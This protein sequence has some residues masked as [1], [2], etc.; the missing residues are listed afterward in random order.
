MGGTHA[1]FDQTAIN[2]DTKWLLVFGEP[3]TQLGQPH[4]TG[5]GYQ[6]YSLTGEP[7]VLPRKTELQGF[8]NNCLDSA[9]A[10]WACGS[11]TVITLDKSFPANAKV[12][13]VFEVGESLAGTEVEFSLGKSAGVVTV[14][15]GTFAVTLT[16]ENEAESSELLI[17]AKTAG[18]TKQSGEKRMLRFVSANVE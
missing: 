5:T 13:L 3:L 6:L 4:L 11:E 10:G 12:D 14:P 17:T 8:S 9:N 16:F 1:E 15:A 7:G 18:V 2:P